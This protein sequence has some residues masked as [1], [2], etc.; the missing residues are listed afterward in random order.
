MTFDDISKNGKAITLKAV[1]DAVSVGFTAM[2]IAGLVSLGLSLYR[3]DA[4]RPIEPAK[5]GEPGEP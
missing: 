1:G 4:G 3:L 5:D 2:A